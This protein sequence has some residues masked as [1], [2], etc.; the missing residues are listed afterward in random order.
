[1]HPVTA[2]VTARIVARSRDA[3]TDYLARI[4]AARSAGVGPEKKRRPPPSPPARPPP[5]VPS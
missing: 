1:M 2:E 3:R 5:L 4:E